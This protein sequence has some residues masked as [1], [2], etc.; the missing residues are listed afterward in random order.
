MIPLLGAA[1]GALGTTVAL[2][3]CSAFTI[4]GSGV[5]KMGPIDYVKSI[6][7]SAPWPI[8]WL[9]IFPIE[10]LGHVIKPTILAFRLFINMLAGHTVLFVILA[11]IW[12]VGPTIHYFLVAPLSVLGQTMLS[13]LELFVAFLQAYVFTYLTALFIGSAVHPH[14]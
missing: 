6:P 7:P 11:F 9:I 12:M 13:C 10:L 2:A 8:K 3:I 4:H 5:A 1:T 14:H